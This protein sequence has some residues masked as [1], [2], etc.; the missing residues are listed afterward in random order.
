MHPLQAPRV[1]RHV[2]PPS[3][4]DLHTEVAYMC[5]NIGEC[6]GLREEGI[7]S[8]VDDGF[9]ALCAQ[10]DRKWSSAEASCTSTEA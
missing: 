6:T 10:L 4:Q 2:L 8:K 3:S 1:T 7:Q 9:V 5:G